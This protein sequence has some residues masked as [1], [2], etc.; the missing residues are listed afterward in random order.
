MKTI[1]TLFVAALLA[2]A[3]SGSCLGSSWQE[4]VRP[5]TSVPLGESLAPSPPSKLKPPPFAEKRQ[6]QFKSK[7]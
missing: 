4:N 5:I 1:A 2:V 7:S 6:S 3:L